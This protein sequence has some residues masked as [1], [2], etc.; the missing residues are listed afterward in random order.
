MSESIKYPTLVKDH[1]QTTITQT[2]EYLVSPD[3]GYQVKII[4]GKRGEASLV[5]KA[6]KIPL[7][8]VRPVYMKPDFREALEKGLQPFGDWNDV[9]ALNHF[10]EEI[11]KRVEALDPKNVFFA[12]S[13]G[14]LLFNPEGVIVPTLYFVDYIHG[15][16]DNENYK[17]NLL[18]EHLNQHP[19]VLKVIP[20]EVLGYRLDEEDLLVV[21]NIPS[22]NASSKR[23][24]YIQF[25][26]LPSQ[27][28][29]IKLFEIAVKY[30][31]EYSSVRLREFIE[32]PEWFQEDEP[33]GLAL[34]EAGVYDPLGLIPFQKKKKNS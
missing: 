32:T 23:S 2:L 34:R 3:I 7:K 21:K 25:Y 26:V 28:T 5:Y 12:Y 4:N 18:I 1:T 27:D 24:R 16:F 30:G 13:S 9:F 19:W 31:G 6:G 22:Y 33:C 14:H 15:C 17:L 29:L 8:G 20:K 10:A 11:P